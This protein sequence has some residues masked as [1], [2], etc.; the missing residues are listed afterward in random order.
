MQTQKNGGKERSDPN[1]KGRLILSWALVP[2]KKIRDNL[3]SAIDLL[4]RDAEWMNVMSLKKFCD[5]TKQ[6]FGKDSQKQ[7]SFSF[8][9]KYAPNRRRVPEDKGSW[10]R[11]EIFGGTYMRRWLSPSLAYKTEANTAK[12][13]L[14]HYLKPKFVI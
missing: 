7:Q 10:F 11:M 14:F 2:G 5:S 3:L 8:G 4:D 9:K 1:S 6:F 12:L 13:S